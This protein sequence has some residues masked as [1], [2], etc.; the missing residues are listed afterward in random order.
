MGML[1]KLWL[2]AR[3]G[4]QCLNSNGGDIDSC[5]VVQAWSDIPCHHDTVLWQ[6]AGGIT[7]R[8]LQ[9]CMYIWCR[10]WTVS[11]QWENLSYSCR[12]RGRTCPSLLLKKMVDQRT[13]LNCCITQGQVQAHTYIHSYQLWDRPLQ[14]H[15][16]CTWS[17]C[18]HLITRST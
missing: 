16:N 10:T 17:R 18:A 9:W 13:C 7:S 3:W 8:F 6:E 15:W 2:V 4:Q 12:T 5:F 1:V 14:S 11:L